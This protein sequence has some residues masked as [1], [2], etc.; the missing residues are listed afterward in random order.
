MQI[1][2]NKIGLNSSTKVQVVNVCA[3]P[4]EIPQQ[5]DN[6]KIFPVY[7]MNKKHWLTLLLDSE[8]TL[9]EIYAFIDKSYKITSKK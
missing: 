8:V 9:K 1:P 6:K 5:I 7:H 3:E 4:E 2:A